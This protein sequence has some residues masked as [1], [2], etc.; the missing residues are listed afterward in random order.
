MVVAVAIGG[1]FEASSCRALTLAGADV[2][3][4]GSQRDEEFRI[5]ARATQDM[6]RKGVHLGNI[7][8]ELSGETHTE[9]GGHGGAAGLSGVGDA[10]AMLHMCMTRT[11]NEFRRIKNSTSPT[12]DE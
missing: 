5:S 10:E 7:M 2:V 12:A 9:G 8:G 6:V 3:F 11:M 4:V 1:S